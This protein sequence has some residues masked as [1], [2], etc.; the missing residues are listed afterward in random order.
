MGVTV[1]SELWIAQEVTMGILSIALLAAVKGKS[2]VRQLLTLVTGRHDG[3][4]SE[5]LAKETRW[6]GRMVLGINRKVFETTDAF[7]L[8]PKLLERLM[9]NNGAGVVAM[10]E[11]F[12][13][14]NIA[15][16]TDA[17]SLGKINSLLEKAGLEKILTAQELKERLPAMRK[18]VVRAIIFSGETLSWEDIKLLQI[19]DKNIISMTQR[20]LNS[21]MR[22]MEGLVN[23]ILGDQTVRHSA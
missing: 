3:A 23:A 6:I 1:R 2:Q 7:A 5:N 9:E 13:G 22:V 10:R 21:F 16:F 19:V 4:I 14:T 8:G 18:P 11:A 17:A 15:A 20:M 12:T